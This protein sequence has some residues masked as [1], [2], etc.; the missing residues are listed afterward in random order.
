MQNLNTHLFLT[1]FKMQ[2]ASALQN[3]RPSCFIFSVL[4]INVVITGSKYPK[5]MPFSPWRISKAMDIGNMTL[6]YSFRNWTSDSVKL[7]TPIKSQH[8]F[9]S[10]IPFSSIR[11]SIWQKASNFEFHLFKITSAW[12]YITWN[13]KDVDFE[14]E[15]TW[16]H[17]VFS[18]KQTVYLL[19][20]QKP[21]WIYF[22]GSTEHY[23]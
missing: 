1:P 11:L 9:N 18:K 23:I 7:W 21:Q 14:I 12:H 17:W 10:E 16:L 8:L 15:N 13:F 3:F 20:S 4:Q 2:S 22:V 19:F 5:T 6:M